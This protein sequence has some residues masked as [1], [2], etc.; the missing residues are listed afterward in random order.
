MTSDWLNVCFIQSK[1]LLQILDFLSSLISGVIKKS[2]GDEN[3]KLM[4]YNVRF[5]DYEVVYGEAAD[6]SL[7]GPCHAIC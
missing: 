6:L 2:S 4:R 7:K 5:E 3:A 1:A